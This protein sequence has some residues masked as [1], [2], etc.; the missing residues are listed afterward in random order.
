MCVKEKP[1]S[2]SLTQPESCSTCFDHTGTR[3][4]PSYQNIQSSPADVPFASGS[5]KIFQPTESESENRYMMSD[6]KIRKDSVWVI[7]S[8]IR[9]PGLNEGLNCDH[10]K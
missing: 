7:K 3:P 2:L 6:A 8:E 5:T 10:M 9:F 1:F 4:Y